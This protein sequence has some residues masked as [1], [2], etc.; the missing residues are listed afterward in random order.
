MDKVAEELMETGGEEAV[1]ALEKAAFET[2]YDDAMEKVAA[3]AFEQGYADMENI[4]E[5]VA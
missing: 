2:G 3:S 4:F 5:Q 1:E